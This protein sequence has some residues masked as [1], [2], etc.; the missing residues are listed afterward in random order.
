MHSIKLKPIFVQVIL[1]YS[2]TVIIYHYFHGVK[3]YLQSLIYSVLYTIRI[4]TR[5]LSLL[6]Q[7]HK[8]S[9]DQQKGQSQCQLYDP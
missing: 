8:S 6:L 3:D 5:S 2:S 1:L 9:D 7:S 4:A